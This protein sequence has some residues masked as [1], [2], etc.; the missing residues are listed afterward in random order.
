MTDYIQSGSG[1]R[2]AYRRSDDAAGNP[3]LVWFSGFNSDMSGSKVLALEAWAAERSIPFLAFDYSGH[4]LSE[5]AFVDGTISGWRDDCLSVIDGLTSDEP[6]VFVGSSMGGWMAL[7]TALAKPGRVAG[8]VLIAPAP[9]FTEKL[10]WASE[11]DEDV[12]RQIM[13]EGVWMRPSEYGEPYPITRALIEDGRQWQIMDEDIPLL[14]PVRILQ[15]VLDDAVPW[16]HSMA[17]VP[18]L[19]SEDVTYTLV[20]DGDHRLSRDQDI[21]RLLRT[22]DELITS[23]QPQ[24]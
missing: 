14:C 21:A 11:F 12:K 13:E 17:L 20:K 5:G 15:G 23:L 9:D 16:E 7:L 22:V 18:K 19:K 2:L 24:E 8:M 1:H 6:L 10:M 4:G 3:R